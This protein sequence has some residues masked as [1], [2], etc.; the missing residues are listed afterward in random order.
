[1]DGSD[2][3][4][5]MI[6]DFWWIELMRIFPYNTGN[7]NRSLSKAVISFIAIKISPDVYQ[8]VF[9]SACPSQHLKS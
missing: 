5:M 9:A 4:E 8:A 6:E 3:N 2:E 7:V 1:M